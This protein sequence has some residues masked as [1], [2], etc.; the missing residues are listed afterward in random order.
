MPTAR[1]K[2]TKEI[3]KS[4]P[5]IKKPWIEV[6]NLGRVRSIDHETTFERCGEVEVHQREGRIKKAPVDSRGRAQLLFSTRENGEVRKHGR[7]LKVLVAEC[8]LPEYRKGMFVYQRNGDLKDC[9]ISNLVVKTKEVKRNIRRIAMSRYKFIVKE[10]DK[11]RGAYAGCE[12]TGR[13]I[14]CTKQAVH[15]AWKTGGKCKGFTITRVPL[16]EEERKE[17]QLQLI[18]AD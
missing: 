18:N 8:F 17:Q 9:R 11:V 1:N 10:G 12:E 4:P 16:S 13:A 2:E 7:L 3:W 14:G 6:S 15:A 5:S